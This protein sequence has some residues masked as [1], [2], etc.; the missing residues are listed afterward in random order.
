MFIKRNDL[1]TRQELYARNSTARRKT[2]WEV[3][4]EKCND[5]SWSL[6]SHVFPC[7]HHALSCSY[8]L[9]LEYE[10]EDGE[11]VYTT[12]TPDRIK[13]LLGVTR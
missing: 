13:T 5:P 1:M 3:V 11:K 10:E 9:G 7:F 2:F 8:A 12:L 4:S 6:Q